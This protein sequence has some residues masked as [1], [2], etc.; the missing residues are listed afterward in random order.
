ML[1]WSLNLLCKC[2][3]VDW[4]FRITNWESY[5]IMIIFICSIITSI[6]SWLCIS[7]CQMLSFYK[8][9]IILIFVRSRIL[10]GSSVFSRIIFWNL[11]QIENITSWKVRF[12]SC[13]QVYC[14][15]LSWIDRTSNNSL[16]HSIFLCPISIF[17][18]KT[19]WQII[20]NFNISRYEF[21]LIMNRN[22]KS[23]IFSFCI[24]IFLIL[25]GFCKRKIVD[26]FYFFIDWLTRCITS[27]ISPSSF[28]RVFRIAFFTIF[29]IQDSIPTP[30]NYM[31]LTLNN[32]TIVWWCR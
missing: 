6:W 26:L 15:A 25:D 30:A 12:Y 8:T 14:F 4:L 31:L 17:Q 1:Y 29:F 27:L 28:L 18:F 23:N 21:S 22:S 11:C 32:C 10:I 7:A 16:D 9:V 13:C 3:I 2:E 5:S 20:S 24:R 19:C